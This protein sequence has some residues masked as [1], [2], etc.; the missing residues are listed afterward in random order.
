V[1]HTR[2]EAITITTPHLRNIP[3]ISKKGAPS[4]HD[5]ISEACHSPG[6][7]VPA[8][9][10]PTPQARL[11]A[12]LRL[13][14]NPAHRLRTQISYRELTPP[15]LQPRRYSRCAKHSHFYKSSSYNLSLLCLLFNFYHLPD[16]AR[17][18]KS[19]ETLF[20]EGGVTV[21]KY[22]EVTLPHYNK[23]VHQRVESGH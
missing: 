14:H 19:R 11:F 3:K 7:R 2:R 20:R 4:S 10:T 21:W 6:C 23:H 16:R 12:Y 13:C 5:P 1:S 15:S 8:R 9:R 18:S 17:N 22:N